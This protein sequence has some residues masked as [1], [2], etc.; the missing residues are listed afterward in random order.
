MFCLLNIKKFL[1]IFFKFSYF[2]EINVDYF[3]YLK[4]NLHFVLGYKTGRNGF[5][6]WLQAFRANPGD[7]L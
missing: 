6:Q 7:L 2:N 4:L 1:P 5:K 3:C